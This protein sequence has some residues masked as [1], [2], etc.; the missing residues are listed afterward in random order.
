MKKFLFALVAAAAITSAPIARQALGDDHDHDH[1]KAAEAESKE[2]Q[3]TVKGEI[4]DLACF[5]GHGA[6]GMD[7]Q[8]CALKCLSSGQ[9]MGLLTADG[10]VYLLMASHE[11]GKP[12]DEAKTLA[13]LQ[14]SVTGPMVNASG[15]KAL[16]VES[17]KKL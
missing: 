6:K 1:A 16:T 5:L 11:D 14:V 7:H 12:F 8:S 3:S 9:P 10:T 13:A 17:V 2:V 4:V 15:I